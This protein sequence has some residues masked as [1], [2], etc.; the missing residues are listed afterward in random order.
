MIHKKVSR[1]ASVSPPPSTPSKADVALWTAVVLAKFL[2]CS[3]W[4]VAMWRCHGTGPK[5]IKIN[6]FVR[7]APSEVMAWLAD[8]TAS[9]TSAHD[10]KKVR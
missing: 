1:H 6:N 8:Q 7:Y 10:A 4:T 2:N 9:S 3:P 5:Y